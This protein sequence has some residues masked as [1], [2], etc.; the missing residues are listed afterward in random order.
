VLLTAEGV[1][2]NVTAAKAP[3]PKAASHANTTKR[4]MREILMDLIIRDFNDA[5]AS[6]GK[7]DSPPAAYQ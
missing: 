3:S 2:E 6:T 5:I 1:T 7:T 4:R